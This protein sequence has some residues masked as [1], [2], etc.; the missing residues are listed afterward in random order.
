LFEVEAGRLE[1][2]GQ[3]SVYVVGFDHR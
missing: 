1:T 3:D 2:V